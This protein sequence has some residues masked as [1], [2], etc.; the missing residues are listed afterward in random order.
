MNDHDDPLAARVRGHDVTAL[1]EYLTAN[2]RQLSAFVERQL[3][4]GLRRKVEVDD[5]FQELSVETVRALPGT[6]FTQRE[7]FGWLCQVAERRI[8]DAHRRFFGAQKR[9][10]G[11]EVPLG[12]PGGDS[13]QAAIIDMLVASMTTPT[14]ALSRNMKEV[15][16]LEALATLPEDQRLV[17]AEVRDSHS[18]LNGLQTPMTRD[19][20]DLVQIVGNTLAIDRL[21]PGKEQ[22]EGDSWPHDRDTI[23]ALL[24]MD[25]VAVCEVTSIVTGEENKQVQI[26]MAGT[27][28]GTID[29]TA[30]EIDLRGAYLFHLGKKRITKFNLAIKEHRTSGEVAPGLDVVAKLKLKITPT[31]TLSHISQEAIAQAEK[32]SGPVSHE[33]RYESSERGMRFRYDDAWYVTAEMRDLLSLRRLQEGSLIAHCNVTTL[34]ARSEGRGTSLEQFERDVRKS[35]GNYLV[36]VAAATQW[37]TGSGHNCLGIIANGKIK[38]VPVQW[39]YYLI[40]SAGMPRVSLA[41]TVEHSQVE[42]F[43]SADRQIVDSLEL[44]D[45]NKDSVADEKTASKPA[46]ATPK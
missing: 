30:T 4:P 39:R 3:G 22:A 32:L 25:H 40:A 43:D 42:Q 21:L 27:V 23:G 38:D 6:D 19:A 5:I 8:I 31:E 12:T 13:R 28:H 20:L 29:G 44:I 37:K 7:V 18:A 46:Q 11:R 2:R 10:A 15:R 9:A 41:V 33:L 16:L 14:Q 36:E 45:I 35:L 24:G 26:R 34:P 1:A 17:L